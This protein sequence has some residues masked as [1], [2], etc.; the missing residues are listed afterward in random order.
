MPRRECDVS[1]LL[2][3]DIDYDI[4][5]AARRL[6]ERTNK[7]AGYALRSLRHFIRKDQREFERELAAVTAGVRGSA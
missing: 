7:Q 1:D 2:P 4:A 5:L 6:R 3:L